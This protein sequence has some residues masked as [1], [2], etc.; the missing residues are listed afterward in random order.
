M[1]STVTFTADTTS[2]DVTVTGEAAGSVAIT[3]SVD[4]AA[5]VDI[6]LPA[7]STVAPAG[8]VGD[9]CAGAGAAGA[10]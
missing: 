10:G 7:G 3:A 5:L 1:P 4:E 2:R 9:G 6:G 8:V